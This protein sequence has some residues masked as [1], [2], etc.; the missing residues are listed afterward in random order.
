[1]S[2]CLLTT[3]FRTLYGGRQAFD[4]ARYAASKSSVT[5]AVSGRDWQ[6]RT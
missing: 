1:M 4:L 3:P 2:K 6:A 5:F